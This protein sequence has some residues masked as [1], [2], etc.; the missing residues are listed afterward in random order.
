MRWTR[1]FTAGPCFT[2]SQ[3]GGWGEVEVGDAHS[4]SPL[5]QIDVGLMVGN[6]QVVFEKAETSSLTLVGKYLLLQ[7]SVLY[8]QSLYVIQINA[9]V[10]VRFNVCISHPTVG[11]TKF[12][13]REN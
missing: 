2:G 3:T 10:D 8:V 7:I 9:Y 13:N 6:S 12:K 5:G 1:G 4:S 11:M